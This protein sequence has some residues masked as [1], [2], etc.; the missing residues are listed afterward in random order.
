[1]SSSCPFCNLAAE[2]IVW[3]SDSVFAIRDGYPVTEGHTLIL[4]VRHVASWFEAS[5][6]EQRAIL[7]LLQQVKADLDAKL[8]PDGYN[9][10][11]NQ[12]AAAGQTVEHLHVHVIPRQAGD[13][14]DPIGGVR[15]VIP[16]RG[17]Y[18]FE[19]H[20][21]R[22]AGQRPPWRGDDKVGVG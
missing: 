22:A 10:G 15:L 5:K 9:V 1:M 13:V 2:R 12:G 3:Q 14:D 20:V 17:N 21:T 18:R 8:S 19:G 7:A 16:E 4:P 11:F 6:E